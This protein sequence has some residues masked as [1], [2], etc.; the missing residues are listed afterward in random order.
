MATHY[1]DRSDLIYFE[2]LNEPHGISDAL[3]NAIQQD[4]VEVIRSVDDSHTIIVGPASWNSFS[5]LAA[6]PIYE[7]DNLIYTFHFYDPFVF[8]HQG[9][10]WSGMQDL[11]GV[12]FPYQAAEM[13]DFPSSLQGT[14]IQGAFNDYQNTGTPE[15]VRNLIDIAVDFSESR[16]VPI[17]CG[18]F[19]VYQPLSDEPDR[20][21]WY[22]VV[23]SYLE[24]KNIA[25][26]MW[27]YHGG[28]GLF[29]EDGNDL[30]E[31]DLN[32]PLLEALG[33]NVPEQTPFSIAPDSTGFMIYDDFIGTNIWNAS[34]GAGD[35]RY[36]NMEQP[37]YGI[38]CIRWSGADQYS[39]ISLDFQPNRDLSYL[40]EQDFVLDF[41]VRGDTPTLSFDIR[42]L[43]TDTADPNDRPWRSRVTISELDVDWNLRW[44][45]LRIPLTDFAEHGAW[46]NNTWYNPNGSFDWTAIDR[47][48]IVAEHQDL[49]GTFLWF[50]QLQI[51]DQDTAVINDNS[52]LVGDVDT[53]ASPEMEVRLFPNPSSDRLYIAPAETE[54]FSY[55]LR[56]SYGRLIEKGDFQGETQ[57]NLQRLPAGLYLLRLS[58]EGDKGRT[59]RILKQ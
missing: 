1:Q 15:Q 14:W 42:F 43:D 8:T 37:N 25:W 48:E 27:D 21:Y 11:G 33:F 34:F 44:H 38:H 23:R 57:I 59:Y 16:Q 40:R 46:E 55:E 4:V 24:E 6:M 19:G 41:F 18:E 20:V 30:F 17:F 3:W 52:V 29:N 58:D 7:D 39:A 22:E 10:S 56:D 47:L 26:T 49:H 28:F 53:P 9:A 13:P 32:V 31:H 12:P 2:V 50:D 51:T 36:Y 54:R 5:N 35:L 45:H